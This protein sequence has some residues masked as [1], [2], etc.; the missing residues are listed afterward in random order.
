MS[1][2]KFIS[3]RVGGQKNADTTIKYNLS[4]PEEHEHFT[5]PENEKL[6]VTEDEVGYISSLSALQLLLHGW[7]STL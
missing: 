2:K 6:K 4:C 5:R 7:M 1:P 3:G